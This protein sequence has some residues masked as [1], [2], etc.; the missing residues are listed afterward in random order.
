MNVF[1]PPSEVF[2]FLTRR[3]I[4]SKSVRSKFALAS[5]VNQSAGAHETS[6][7]AIVRVR[8]S[9]LSPIANW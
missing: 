8:K 3:S 9:K 2:S 7:L 1:A 6:K 5:R 4:D